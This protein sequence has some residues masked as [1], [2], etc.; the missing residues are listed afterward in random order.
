MRCLHV[1]SIECVYKVN[2]FTL[3]YVHK[4]IIGQ[5]LKLFHYEEVYVLRDSMVPFNIVETE[6][7]VVGKGI[8]S[9]ISML[10]SCKPSACSIPNWL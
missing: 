3:S 2:V 7:F 9:Y 5:A 8:A 6:S 1:Y 10:C 4:Q